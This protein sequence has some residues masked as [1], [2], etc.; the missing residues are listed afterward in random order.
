MSRCCCWT[1]CSATRA[2]ADPAAR[3]A[4]AVRPR[5]LRR[6]RRQRCPWWSRS[7]ARTRIRRTGTAQATAFVAAGA[8]VYAPTRPRRGPPP[9]SPRPAAGTR[10]GTATALGP[11][12]PPRSPQPDTRSRRRPR[13]ERRPVRRGGTVPDLLAGP[14]AVISA[15]ID[16]LADALRAQAVDVTTVDFRPPS[17]QSATGRLPTTWPSCCADPRRPAADAVA[18]QRMLAGPGRT[19]R[20]QARRRGDRPA[21][22]AV[23]PRRSA[24]R[25]LPGPPGRCAARS[26][27]R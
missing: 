25:V 17:R 18:A 14:P 8:G 26:S 4:P 10:S 27:A 15:G 11:P 22:A 16:L 3:L 12:P 9:R 13:A 7:A 5:S 24:D 19:G 6:R 21:A 1:W 2:D 20:C 23:L